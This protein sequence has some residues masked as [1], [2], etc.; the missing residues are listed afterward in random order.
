[1][2]HGRHVERGIGASPSFWW[3]SGRG[4]LL[5]AGACDDGLSS[6]N[7]KS[8]LDHSSPMS[9]WTASFLISSSPPPKCAI[10]R[11]FRVTRISWYD[12]NFTNH[13]VCESINVIHYDLFQHYHCNAWCRY[14]SLLR[15]LNK[16][17]TTT[18]YPSVLYSINQSV[19][20]WGNSSLWW[21][22]QQKKSKKNP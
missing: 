2:T 3:R 16:H 13:A 22:T 12:R 18:V 15:M 19:R 9:L 14:I 20:R 5:S 7:L 11:N 8:D 17:I 6:K 4:T 10:T 21:T 1:M